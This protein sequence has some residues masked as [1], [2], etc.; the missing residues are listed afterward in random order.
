MVCLFYLQEREH[1]K[2]LREEERVHKIAQSIQF[3]FVI[4]R[5]YFPYSLKYEYIS[6]VLGLFSQK[7][8]TTAGLETNGSQLVT[9]Y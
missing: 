8:M 9:D 4:Y 5:P 7:L 1:E 6:V 2:Q 3:N